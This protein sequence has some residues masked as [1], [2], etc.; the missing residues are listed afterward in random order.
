M[1]LFYFKAVIGQ[2]T[3]R[4]NVLMLTDKLSVEL[5]DDDGKAIGNKK[6][7]V[8]F[9]NGERRSGTL[10]SSGKAEVPKIAPG[11]ADFK[12]DLNS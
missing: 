3:L 4:S 8:L 6:Y 1:P 10:D 7:E 5:K 9:P 12:V 11:T 2:L